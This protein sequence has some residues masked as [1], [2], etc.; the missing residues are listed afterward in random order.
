MQNANLEPTL[1]AGQEQFPVVLVPRIDLHIFCDNQQTGQVLQAAAADRRLSRAH[2]TV[3][4]G[5]I[6]AAAQVYQ[7]QPTPNVL[8]VES[9]NG[10]DQLMGELSRLAEVCQ[11]NT[12]VIVIGH[13]NDVL[14]Y[15]ELIKAGIAEYIVAPVSPVAFIELIASLYTDPKSSP[16]GRIVSFLGAKGGVGSSTIAHNLAWAT[17]QKQGVDTIIT[18]LDLAFGTASLN[19]NQD[20][21]G[22]ILEALNQPDRLDSTLVERMMTKLGNKLSLLNGPGSVERDFN[23]EGHAVDA[24]L[25]V[26]R[27]SAPLVMVDVPNMWAPWIK[28]TL[29]NSDEII[30]TATP[31]LPSLRNAKNL[32]DLFK[33]ARANDRPPRLI[34]NQVGVP[35]RPEIAPADF[36]KA[37]GVT[38]LAVIPHDPAAF[39]LAQGNGQ[40]LHEVAPKSKASEIIN[41]IAGTI[42]G[43]SAPVAKPKNESLLSKVSIAQE[44]V[45]RTKGPPGCLAK[46]QKIQHHKVCHFRHRQ[47]RNLLLPKRLLCLILVFRRTALRQHRQPSLPQ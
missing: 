2:V 1:H 25:N 26:V 4:L 15:R 30:I 32:M 24:I 19:F 28:H 22:G 23:I 42:A 12:K 16:L 39:G 13:V 14:L 17:S 29:L 35:K 8:V 5:G 21:S 31:E 44:E 7:T 45:V 33:A 20:G 9:H 46:D 40:M 6:P 18:D 37:L 3:Q 10:H 41:S 38:P 27:S 43:Q 47:R 36:A 11:A 34:I